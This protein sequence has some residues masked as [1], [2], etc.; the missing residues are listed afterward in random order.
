VACEEHQAQD[1]AVAFEFALWT[2]GLVGE[3][4]DEQFGVRHS[5]ATLSRLLR[6]LGFSVQRPLYRAW[7]QDPVVVERWLEEEYPKIRQ[8]AK[9]AGATIFFADE[10]G[11]HSDY[12]AGT[13]W[14]VRGETPIVGVDRG[15]SLV[16]IPAFG[17][18]IVGVP[19]PE[20]AL[21]K[22]VQNRGHTELQLFGFDG[23]EGDPVGKHDV[24]HGKAKY[25]D[26][27]FLVLINFNLSDLD[28]EAADENVGTRVPALKVQEIHP[29][30]EIA[31]KIVN[32]LLLCLQG[33]WSKSLSTNDRH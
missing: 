2:L 20:I 18:P 21:F 6:T 16:G 28:G 4:I 1:A 17:A 7:Q 14:A 10:S 29:G 3:V 9:K 25:N 19:V 24:V 26:Y 23:D 33:G 27:T 32:S 8:A 15:E 11:I 5:K 22:S 30:T 31:Y 13:T 12:H